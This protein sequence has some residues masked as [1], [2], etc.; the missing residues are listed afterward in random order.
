[1]PACC[2]DMLS[3]MGQPKGVWRNRSTKNSR[4]PIDNDQCMH[5]SIISRDS[6]STQTSALQ[7]NVCTQGGQEAEWTQ[8]MIEPLFSRK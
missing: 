6:R 5:K 7:K 4:I 2:F 8:S 3:G 1:M